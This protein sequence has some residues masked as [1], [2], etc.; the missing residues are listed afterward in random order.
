LSFPRLDPVFGPPCTESG[1]LGGN[2]YIIPEYQSEKV[3]IKKAAIF[4]I[5][6]DGT[7]QIIGY[8]DKDALGFIPVK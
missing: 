7:E 5:S 6:P 2:K 4:E 1:F 3:F 8:W